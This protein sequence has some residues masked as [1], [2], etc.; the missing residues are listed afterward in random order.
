MTRVAL[1]QINPTVGDIAGNVSTILRAWQAAAK[2]KADLIVFPELALIGYP[3]EDLVLMPA[4]RKEAMAAVKTLAKKTAKGPAMLVGSVWEKKG[5]V[6]NAAL[7]L[8]H[9]KIVHVQTKT[10]LPNYGVFD[11]KRIFSIGAGPKVIKWRGERLGILVCEDTWVPSLSK[12]LGKQKPSLVISINASPFEAGKLARRKKIAAAAAKTAKAPLIYVNMVGGQDDIVFDGG[13]FAVEKQGKLTAQLPEFVETVVIIP[14]PGGG[15]L[16]RGHKGQDSAHNAPLPASPLQGEEQ[17]WEA[18][19]LGLADYVRKNS[20]KGVVLGLSGGI[21]SAISAAA[22]VEA[23]GSDRVHGVLLPSPYNSKGSIE[24]A[25]ELAANLGIA[26]TNISITPGMQTLEEVLN[27]AFQ[28]SGWMEDVSIGGNVQSRL[29]G[30]TLM[31]MSNR[32]GWML[33]STANKSEIAVGYSTLYGDS[34]GGYNL[35]KDL[36]KTQ[37]YELAQWCNRAGEIIPRRSITKPPSAELAPGQKDEDQLPPYKTLDAILLLH[38]EGRKS[39]K[40]IIARGYKKAVVEQVV[41]M[42]RKSEYKRRQSCPG[43]K[44]SS[45]QFGKDRRYPLTNGVKL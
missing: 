28:Y 2:Q 1:A 34:C 8:D 7:L 13:S 6:Y 42:V 41:E 38:I 10:A 21:D 5:R 37:I 17:I 43:V 29:R 9:G 25:E 44:L 3:P 23:L 27:P 14:S 22:A 12:A 30:L 26:I 4:F 11:E 15:G 24:D 16:G 35:L 45:M 36:Y 19:K 39:A 18:M 40:E 31:A 20:F 32:F 33:L